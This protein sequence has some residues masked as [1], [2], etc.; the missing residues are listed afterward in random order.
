MI[1]PLI[2][3]ACSLKKESSAVKSLEISQAKQEDLTLPSLYKNCEVTPQNLSL[4]MPLIYK[5]NDLRKKTGAA[6]SAL[7]QEIKITGLVLDSKCNPIS[8]ALVQIW[9][10]DA[11]GFYKDS[12]INNYLNE[13]RNYGKVYNRFT[14]HYFS[15]E[16]DPNFTGS[17]S[18]TTDNLG[19]F[20][21]YSIMPG[22]GEIHFRIAHKI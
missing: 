14:K 22:K 13:N 11:K 19:R 9:Q 5:S 15:D 3:T 10:S 4:P 18:T 20:V 17:G 8:S 2:M 1:L 21:F 6:I 16:A 7:G 12:N